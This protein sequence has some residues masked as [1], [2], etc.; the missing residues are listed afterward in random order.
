MA[1]QQGCFV[2]AKTLQLTVVLIIKQDLKSQISNAVGRQWYK[3]SPEDA[4]E[5]SGF[6]HS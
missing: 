2:D 3:S 4:P 6:R 5:G 1:S